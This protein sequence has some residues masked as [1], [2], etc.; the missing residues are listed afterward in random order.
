MAPART[1][2]RRERGRRAL[3]IGGEGADV[4]DAVGVVLGDDDRLAR[5]QG[6][7][8]LALQVVRVRLAQPQQVTGMRRLQLDVEGA[9]G[10]PDVDHPGDVGD[11]QARDRLGRRVDLHVYGQPLPAQAVED[12]GEAEGAR[13][14]RVQARPT[15]PLQLH[16]Q[17]ALGPQQ[18]LRCAIERRLET[19]RGRDDRVEVQHH[20]LPRSCGRTWPFSPSPRRL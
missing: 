8:Q 13:V 19:N 1:G 9:H 14:G 4:D 16:R 3:R 12:P 15:P 6:L 7:A 2:E 5:L 17:A 20:D 10:R 11:E 18:F